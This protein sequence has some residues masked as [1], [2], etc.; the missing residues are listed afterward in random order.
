M[1]IP[2]ET[3]YASLPA[4]FHARQAP[5]PVRAPRLLALNEDLARALGLDPEALRSAAGVAM[6]AGNAVPAGAIPIA[7]AYAGHQFGG[8]VPQLGD[9]RAV[10][11]GELRDRQGRLCDL[12]LKGAGRTPFS[13]GGDGRAWLGPVLREYLVSEAMAALGIPT[14]RALA[15][16]GTG[17]TVLREAPL[18]GAVLVRVA[19][20]HLRIGTFQ[21][22]AAR[23]DTE[24]VQ[25]LTDHAIARHYPGA[26]TAADLLRAVVARQARLVALWMGVG[27]VHGVMNTDNTHIGGETIDY[28]PCAFL[29]GFDPGA[30]FS[31]ID[32]HGRYGYDRQ[33]DVL[34]WNLVQFASTL[35][36]LMGDNAVDQAQAVID[37]FGDLVRAEWL[38]VFRAKLGLIGADP[39]DGALISDL[40]GLMAAERADFTRSFRAL[41]EGT[42]Q[43]LFADS[44]A[45]AA[46]QTR[47][48]ARTG[49]R[50]DLA[51][52]MKSANPALIPRNHRI[53][54][55]IAAAVAGDLAPMQRLHAALAR[56][57]DDLPADLA[58]LALPPQ[59][60]ERVHATFC[61]T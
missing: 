43:E 58:D 10:L 6:L 2:F 16:L 44:A 37:G 25:I 39:G 51:A 13:R 41:A 28:G 36:P 46:W 47:W 61:G 7:Q 53:E 50:G 27:F 52:R 45:F 29:D 22:F 60:H 9:G 54:Q 23:R 17:E 12:V 19:T 35:L 3:R 34:A 42:A 15:A 11:L 59:E 26:E 8:F 18:P 49:A 32:R 24:A 40:L 20:S 1:Q 57:Y 48:Q 5:T 33:P 14:T 21:Y 31:S 38:A 55:A 4:R 56:P 30:V